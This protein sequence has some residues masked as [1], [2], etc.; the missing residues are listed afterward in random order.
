MGTT[1]NDATVRMTKNSTNAE[2]WTQVGYFSDTPRIKNC[3]RHFRLK[4]GFSRIYRKRLKGVN[5]NPTGRI[6][7]C[8][9]TT[10]TTPTN[11]VFQYFQTDWRGRL[12]LSRDDYVTISQPYFLR[13]YSDKTYVKIICRDLHVCKS[14]VFLVF[15]VAD[16]KSNNSFAFLYKLNDGSNMADYFKTNAAIFTQLRH[17]YET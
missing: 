13:I 11:L 5:M 10:P 4:A 1:S 8:Q 12:W 16:Y 17:N 2:I 15:L 14:L 6:H 9:S 7:A 3:I